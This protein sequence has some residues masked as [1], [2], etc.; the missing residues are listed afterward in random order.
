MGGVGGVRGFRKC[1]RWNASVVEQNEMMSMFTSRLQ[2]RHQRENRLSL[3]I[4][5]NG[6]GRQHETA[7]PKACLLRNY[8]SP[9]RALT[10]PTGPSPQFYLKLRRPQ[11][12]PQAQSGTPCP[13]KGSPVSSFPPCLCS[14]WCRQITRRYFQD[15]KP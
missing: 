6:G 9:G 10:P 7:V 3:K 8:K 4:P 5:S 1:M 14:F 2:V 11:V 15:I 12:P 13:G